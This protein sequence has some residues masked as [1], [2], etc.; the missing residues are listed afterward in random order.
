LANPISLPKSIRLVKKEKEMTKWLLIILLGV[1]LS[2]AFTASTY[3]V[4]QY[5]TLVFTCATSSNSLGQEKDENT[6]KKSS[7]G[8]PNAFYHK[9]SAPDNSGC[10]KSDSKISKLS[11]DSQGN[12]VANAVFSKSNFIKD[13]EVWGAVTFAGIL[14]LFGVRKVK[15]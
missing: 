2:V 15:W 6:Y 3:F 1:I 14:I 7:Y 13:L 4:A 11:Y 9:Y 10:Q 5:E 12:I 8:F